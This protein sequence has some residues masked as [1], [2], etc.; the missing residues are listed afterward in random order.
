MI[1]SGGHPFSDRNLAIFLDSKGIQELQVTELIYL[2]QLRKNLQKAKPLTQFGTVYQ[3]FIAD[4][5]MLW[6]KLKSAYLA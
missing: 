1:C 2:M 6:Y 5:L 3:L 4:K